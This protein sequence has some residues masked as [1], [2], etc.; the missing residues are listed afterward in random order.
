MPVAPLK[1]TKVLQ[2][3]ITQVQWSTLKKLKGR[4]IKVPQFIREA[5]KEKIDREAVEL[6]EKPKKVDCPF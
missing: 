5:I 4:N 1:Y 3:P 2:T 6:R